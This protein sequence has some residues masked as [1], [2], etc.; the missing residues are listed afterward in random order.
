MPMINV[1]AAEGTFSNA[2]DLTTNL[3]AARRELAGK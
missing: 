3:A 2:H 1:H